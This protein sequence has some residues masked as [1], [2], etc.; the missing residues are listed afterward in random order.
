LVNIFYKNLP[1][2]VP[3]ETWDNHGR[4]RITVEKKDDFTHISASTGAFNFKKDETRKF[5]FELHVTPLKPIDYKKAFSVR[6]SHNSKLKNEIKEIDNA[7]K[8][9]LTHV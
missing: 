1:L 8:N 9:G 3:E 6:Y 2:K 5:I 7:Y 4:G